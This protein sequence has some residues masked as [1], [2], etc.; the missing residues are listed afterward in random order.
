MID[1]GQDPTD[2]LAKAKQLRAAG[3]STAD[4][5]QYL[6]SKGALHEGPI[7]PGHSKFSPEQL[8]RRAEGAVTDAKAEEP[9]TVEKVTGGLSAMANQLPVVPTYLRAMV[10]GNDPT[11]QMPIGAGVGFPVPSARD[12]TEAGADIED[13]QKSNPRVSNLADRI[14][15]TFGIVATGAPRAAVSVGR[16]A[17]PFMKA[18]ISPRRALAGVLR[19]ALTAAPEAAPAAVPKASSLLE[20]LLPVGADVGEA[21][22]PRT[23]EAGLRASRAHLPTLEQSMGGGAVEALSPLTAPVSESVLH[24]AMH[25]PAPLDARGALAKLLQKALDEGAVGETVKGS[26]ITNDPIGNPDLLR[27]IE[28]NLRGARPRFRPTGGQSSGRSVADVL[29]A[30]RSP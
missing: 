23:A 26:P 13:A 18:A 10:R 5:A 3:V 24:E 22:A 12:Y 11:M 20:G 28:E 2:Y 16:A 7:T 25:T 17:L 21:G 6:R 27:S 14:S 19:S 1:E 30:K 9:T 8:T 29:R 15:G 4:I